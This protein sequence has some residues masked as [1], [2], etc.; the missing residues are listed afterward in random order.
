MSTKV[1]AVW[2][3]QQCFARAVAKDGRFKCELKRNHPGNHA[4]ERGMH[5]I[6]WGKATWVEGDEV[7]T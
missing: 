6:A 5:W 4:A 1:M 2:P 3:W 7:A